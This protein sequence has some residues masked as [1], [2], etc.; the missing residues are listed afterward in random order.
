MTLHKSFTGFLAVDPAPEDPMGVGLG[1]GIV[2]PVAIPATDTGAAAELPAI[3]TA[4]TVPPAATDDPVVFLG[5][6]TL[7]QPIV[8]DGPVPTLVSRNASKLHFRDLA[9]LQVSKHVATSSRCQWYG[10]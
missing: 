10:R 6:D 2:P 5:G 3:L 8:A 1:G 7:T 4:A 9:P